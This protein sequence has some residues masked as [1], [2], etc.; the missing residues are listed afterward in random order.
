MEFEP[1]TS[2]VQGQTRHRPA[3]MRQQN[4]G[5]SVGVRRC[6]TVDTEGLHHSLWHRF[7][8]AGAVSPEPIGSE[9]SKRQGARARRC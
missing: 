9:L 8:V 6:G 4:R 5:L 2:C 3:T 1:T 7:S